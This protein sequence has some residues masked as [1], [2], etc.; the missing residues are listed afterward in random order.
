VTAHPGPFFKLENDYPSR[1]LDHFLNW[2]VTAQPGPFSKLEN[3][4][5]FIN[6]ISVLPPN[7]GVINSLSN[8]EVIS[9]S[10]TCPLSTQTF[11]FGQ[12]TYENIYYIL[13]SGDILKNH[14]SPLDF[15]TEKIILDIN[16]IQP[17]M[18]HRVPS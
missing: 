12:R 4:Y 16:V 7:L 15:I 13:I 14:L 1:I 10:P 8:K 18:E 2:K 11:H 5:P 3:D 9:T 17:I 6:N